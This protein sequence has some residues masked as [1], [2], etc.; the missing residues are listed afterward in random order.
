MYI[1]HL[2]TSS[3]GAGPL[4]EQSFISLRVKQWNEVDLNY[5]TE[6]LLLC[7]LTVSTL[8][9][10]VP[11]FRNSPHFSIGLIL[12]DV[13][14][15]LGKFKWSIHN[16]TSTWNSC[17]KEIIKIISL[18]STFH[19]LFMGSLINIVTCLGLPCFC[20]NWMKDFLTSTFGFVLSTTTLF[21]FESCS[22]QT[23]I[24]NIL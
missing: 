9:D 20:A 18:L 8:V 7:G 1:E 13:I 3:L 15:M 23:C 14:Q 16:K 21:P 2:A 4:F 6:A 17:K 24:Y 5:F 12:T 19:V 22:L 10:I 11:H